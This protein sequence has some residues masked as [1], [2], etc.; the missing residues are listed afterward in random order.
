MNNLKLLILPLFFSCLTATATAQIV[1]DAT[2]PVNSTVIPQGNTNLIEGGTQK[3]NNLFHSFEQFSVPTDTQAFFNNN[4]DIQNIFTR[5]TGNSISRID[6]I[7][8]ANGTANL[9][10]LNPNGI[11]FGPNAQLNLGGSFVA[12]TANS[13]LF[14]DGTEFSATKP[15]VA[16]V[17][18]IN[19]P[20]GLQFNSPSPIVVQGSNLSV[21][22]GQTLAIVG[23]DITISGSNDPFYR[24]LSAGGIPFVI[25]EGNPIPTTR[26]GRVELGSV[27]QGTV[28][29]NPTQTGV[30][31]NYD[32]AQTFGNIQLN[33]LATVD[34]SGTGGGEIQ[35]SGRNLQI[36]EG[37]RISSITLGSDRGGNITVNTTDSVAMNGTGGYDDNVRRF[38]A[39]TIG[40]NDLRNGLFTVSLGTGSAGN[41]IV[42]TNNFTASNGT[43]IAASTFGPGR[44]GNVTVN[45]SG[46]VELSSSFLATGTGVGNGGDAGNLTINTRNFKARDNAIVTTATIGAG[47]GGDLII[48]ALDSV[49]LIGSN[50]IPIAP[51]VRVF[52][53][54]FSSG[55]NTGKAGE[56]Q[57]N[58]ERLTVRSGAG[59]AA[60]SFWAGD[61]GN[62]TVNASESVELI[63]TSPD[64]SALS[65]IAAVTEPGSSGRG[66]N[67]TV[68]TGYLVLQDGGRLSVRSRGTGRT[69]NLDVKADTILLNN[70]GGFEGTAVSGEGADIN[71][72]SLSL[73]IS[74]YSFI[75]ATAGI[76]GG[77][78][79]GGN[80]NIYTHTLVVR[81]NSDITANAFLGKGGNI[82][83]DS[84]GL[85][86]SNNS[87]ITA[88]SQNGF[89]GI[90]QVRTINSNLPN[91]LAPLASNFA[92][93]EAV[94]ATNCLHNGSALQNNFTPIGTGGLPSNPYDALISRY[95]VTPIQ[96]LLQSWNYQTREITRLTTEKNPDLIQEAQGMEILDDGRIILGTT[97]QIAPVKSANSLICHQ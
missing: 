95:N 24:G 5:V 29:L 50:P 51:G 53:G 79:N 73:Q 67:L 3:G 60:S 33:N 87:S 61:G 92:V 18:T 84:F 38:V 93:S 96:N 77:A 36:N 68:N 91:A 70:E 71:V 4:L 48:N 25:V 82:L 27:E 81:E 62:I 39:G 28:N 78:G 37:S 90:V 44:G 52:T 43:Y 45:A 41:T 56:L 22:T 97:S 14:A 66:G 58:A 10:L 7:L 54:F 59:L 1:P 26:G 94:L 2:L 88:S 23:G 89:S 65:S 11:I 47:K 20:I 85:F 86:R 19:V 9:F 80:I 42:N 16:P 32:N 49:E 13:L 46:T 6:G 8:K 69:G 30:N 57:V 64:A 76:E 21:A 40:L 63:G 55:L 34:T 72:R 15:T 75:S 74:N 83:I 35:M 31:L 12:T 17:L